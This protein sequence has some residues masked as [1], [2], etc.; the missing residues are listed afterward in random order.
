MM[1]ALDEHRLEERL[2]RAADHA[3]A[4]ATS[5]GAELAVRRGRQRG[6]RRR[7]AAA[8]L[9]VAALAGVGVLV[10]RLSSD[11]GNAVVAAP[12][13]GVVRVPAEG[14]ELPVP[15]GWR[16]QRELAGTHSA[17]NAGSSRSSVIGVVLVPS[18]GRPAGAA[19]TVTTDVYDDPMARGL[20][21]RR[22]GRSF[23]VLPGS[24]KGEVGRV[25]L[26]W[27]Q[28][29]CADLDACK[30]PRQKKL[31]GLLVTGTAAPGDP[32]GRGQVLE[33]LKQVAISVR[34]I[35]NALVPPPAPTVPDSTKVLLGTGGSGDAVWEAWIRPLDGNAGFAMDFPRG[36]PTPGKHW[37]QLEPEAIARDGVTTQM[38]C[39][40]WMPGSGLVLS[41]LANKDAAAV[42]IELQG[43]SPVT[44]GTFGR[45]KP[46]PW[47]AFVSPALPPGSKVDRVVALGAA[48][49]AIGTQEHPFEDTALCPRPTR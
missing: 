48:G 26:P 36:K 3:A 20:I 44:V 27:A 39:L 13:G 49:K 40:S 11:D 19:I 38:D 16:V 5:P 14:F 30:W 1:P 42:R 9:V 15:N 25:I 2:R 43:Q 23:A 12:G 21:K 35:T 7:G 18:S 34:A 33:V 8:L 32:A 31:R 37:E 6:R 28:F 24:G 46:I 17:A 10:P 47:V 29:P 4:A 45:D 22:D 41:G